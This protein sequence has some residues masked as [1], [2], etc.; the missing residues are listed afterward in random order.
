MESAYIAQLS[1]KERIAL[2]IARR[3]LGASFNLSRS[4]GYVKFKETNIA[5][6][7]S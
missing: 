6:S 5:V 2:D 3:M 1:D 4:H 7:S